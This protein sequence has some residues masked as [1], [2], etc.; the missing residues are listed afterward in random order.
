MPTSIDFSAIKNRLNTSPVD[1]ES[2]GVP[3]P[4]STFLLL[5]SKSQHDCYIEYMEG[6]RALY[7]FLSPVEYPEEYLRAIDENYTVPSLLKG[8][9]SSQLAT[10]VANCPPYMHIDEK[11][12]AHKRA[13]RAILTCMYRDVLVELY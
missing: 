5:Y 9:E 2:I 4:L 1:A 10:I 12:I 8:Y 7:A 3:T 11:I 13:E 6:A